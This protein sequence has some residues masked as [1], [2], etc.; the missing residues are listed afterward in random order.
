MEVKPLVPR[1]ILVGVQVPSVDDA[2]H[3]A[4]L[5]ELGRLVKTLGYEI[6][7]TVSQKRAAIDGSAVLGKGRLAA[8]AAMTGGKGI[9][10]S[11]AVPRKSKARERFEDAEDQAPEAPIAEPEQDA[12]QKP[13]FVIVDHELSP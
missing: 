3:A 1:A 8:L 9:V 2:A 11:G 12:A 10:E 13:G 7:A 4:S 6:V 5:A